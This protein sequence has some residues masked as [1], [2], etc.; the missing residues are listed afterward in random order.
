MSLFIS[1]KSTTRKKLTEL[2]KNFVHINMR[3]SS[4]N[5]VYT[6]YF[7]LQPLKRSA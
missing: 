5:N 4:T 6:L 2:L 1:F 3:I 7:A